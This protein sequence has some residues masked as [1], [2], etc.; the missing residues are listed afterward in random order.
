MI[1]D[2]IF[3]IPFDLSKV[4]D[5]EY[6][7]Y[8]EYRKPGVEFLFVEDVSFDKMLIF[9]HTRYDFPDVFQLNGENELSISNETKLSFWIDVKKR[10]SKR[11]STRKTPCN[12]YEYTTCINV[13][14][15]KLILER[16]DCHVPALYY[17]HHLDDLIP[18]EI[19]KC[20]N[21]VTREAFD[22]ILNK[23]SN[24]TRSPTCKMTRFTSNIKAKETYVKNTDLVW[25]AFA[26]PEVASYNTY[27][28]YDLLSLIGEVGGILG[29]TLGASVLNLF[30]LFLHK[31]PYY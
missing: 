17:G 7:A 19:L 29:L 12:P 8:E 18:K 31:N 1:R 13:E 23:T 14:D 15:N 9:L 22:L 24:C 30:E 5:F 4:K 27:I 16:F 20:S 3:C 26:N 11:E 2:N 21:E 25:I 10:V 28:S 6:I